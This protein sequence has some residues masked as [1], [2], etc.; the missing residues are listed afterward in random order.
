MTIK[1][2]VIE[3]NPEGPP[4][5]DTFYVVGKIKVVTEKVEKT[6]NIERKFKLD[7]LKSRFDDIWQGLG[8]DIKF[9]LRDSR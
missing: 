7:D 2:V 8:E 6:V 3:V 5:D 4:F 9:S 1:K